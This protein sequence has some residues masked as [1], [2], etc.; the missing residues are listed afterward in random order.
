MQ[1]FEKN[2]KVILSFIVGAILAGGISVYATESYFA[3]QIKYTRNETEMTVSQALNY[4]YDN[5]VQQSD[6]WKAWLK[7]MNEKGVKIQ[8]SATNTNNMIAAST[9]TQYTTKAKAFNGTYLTGGYNYT[10]AWLASPQTSNDYIGYEFNKKVMIYKMTLNYSSYET[11]GQ[12]SFVLEGKKENG[13]WEEIGSEYL[14]NANSQFTTN[15]YYINNSTFY[16]GYRIKNNYSKTGHGKQY[17]HVQGSAAL[18]IGELQF[19]CIE[20]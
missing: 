13:S 4:L 16:Y 15:D 9:N 14:I 12:Y 5:I 10:E 6:I 1:I 8:P 18:A 7:I 11:T 2:I 20:N 3:T 19:Y 17:W